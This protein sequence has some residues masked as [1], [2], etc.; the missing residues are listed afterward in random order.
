MMS[1]Y[2]IPVASLH[3]VKKEVR[4]PKDLLV[5]PDVCYQHASREIYSITDTKASSCISTFIS[6][7]P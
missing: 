6:L 7:N 4:V 5:E 1:S 2:Q 3:A